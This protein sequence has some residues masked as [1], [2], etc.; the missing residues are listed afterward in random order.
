[1]AKAQF[2]QLAHPYNPAKTN[3]NGWFI[4]EKLDGIR[5]FWDGGV[6]RGLN[7]SDVPWA[8]TE[9]DHI[10]VRRPVS[11]GL[12][13]RYGNVIYAPDWFVDQLPKFPLD[14][15]L[16]AGRGA[17]QL[18]TST[19][20]D[21]VP[22]AGWKRI[23]F[24]VLDSPPPEQ[25][26]AD[27]VIN[28]VNFKKTFRDILP[29][30]YERAGIKIP[31]RAYLTFEN[32]YRFLIRVVD[33]TDNFRI[34]MQEQLPFMTAAANERIESFMN[35]VLDG[36][37][38]GIVLRRHMSSWLPERV[39]TCLKYK[40]YSDAEATVIGYVWGRETDKGSKLLGLMG[41]LVVKMDNGKVFELSGFTDAERV[42]TF[43]PFP[44]TDLVNASVGAREGQIF[45]GQPV[46]RDWFN[47]TFRIGTRVTY[48]YRELTDGGIP[49]E[50][51]YLRKREFAA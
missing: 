20:K 36:D 4:S 41:A 37:G 25:V 39:H 50:A 38:E 17:H 42:M 29:W 34:H 45:P 51:R 11:T 32:M 27:R 1:M 23:V 15:E 7:A 10:R 28:E 5:A 8:N 49:K 43:N 35:A 13:S 2:L 22:G 31:D 26:F 3:V 6:S 9:K 46:S 18:T 47:P 21:H 44:G 12:W 40:P 16:H 14:G 48:K 30:Y 33:P 24:D 19:V